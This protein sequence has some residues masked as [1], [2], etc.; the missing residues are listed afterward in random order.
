MVLLLGGLLAMSVSGGALLLRWY[1]A[2]SWAG[3]EEA[4]R[5]ARQLDAPPPRWLDEP[6]DSAAARPA[7]AARPAPERRAT[8]KPAM[9]A[10][11]AQPPAGRPDSRSSRP[12][13]PDTS[14]H[15]GPAVGRPD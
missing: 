2:E 7:G 14:E 6:G 10:D 1:A 4:A 5:A 15:A 11:G 8:P 9:V 12:A 13:S 3:S